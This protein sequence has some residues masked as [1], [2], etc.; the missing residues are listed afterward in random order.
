MPNFF[1]ILAEAKP[2]LRWRAGEVRSRTVYPRAFKSFGRGSVIVAPLKLKG[3][4]RISVGENVAI[5]DG[6]WLHAESSGAI[7]IADYVYLGHRSHIAAVDRISIGESC[8]LTDGC[9][10]TNG[11][12][13]LIDH[14]EITSTGPNSIGKNCFIGERAIVLGGV[15]VGDNA[16]IGAGAVVTKDIPAGAVVAKVPAKPLNT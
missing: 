12:H 2:S 15:T 7:D 9:T 14:D 1:R 11:V 13:G 4:E 10:L 6:A 5:F 3:V 16:I 8:M